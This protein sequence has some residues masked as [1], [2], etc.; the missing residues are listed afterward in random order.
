MLVIDDYKSNGFVTTNNDEQVDAIDVGPTAIATNSEPISA[1][2]KRSNQGVSAPRMPETPQLCSCPSGFY[3]MLVIN[4]KHPIRCVRC[5]PGFVTSFNG[6][7]CVRCFITTSSNTHLNNNNTCA[8]IE[9]SCRAAKNSYL[10]E[11]VDPSDGSLQLECHQCSSTTMADQ[12]THSC[13][14]CPA[15]RLWSSIGPQ[16]N[17]GPNH[18][19][20]RIA[21]NST[22]SMSS[23]IKPQ[24]SWIRPTHDCSCHSQTVV[25]TT[26]TADAQQEQD[27]QITVTSGGLCMQRRDYIATVVQLLAIRP[28]RQSANNNNNQGINDESIKQSVAQLIENSQDLFLIDGS[29]FTVNNREYSNDDESL[30]NRHRFQASIQAEDPDSS[31]TQSSTLNGWQSTRAL[32]KFKYLRS[33]FMSNHLVTAVDQCKNRHNLT[34]CQL[35]SNICAYNLYSYNERDQ[36]RA[37]TSLAETPTRSSYK[38]FNGIVYNTDAIVG[39]NNVCSHLRDYIRKGTNVNLPKSELFSIYIDNDAVD[40]LYKLNIPNSYSMNQ[41]IQIVAFRYAE[42]GQM[43]DIVPF[44][45]NHLQ[46]SL[47]QPWSSLTVSHN[48][49]VQFGD[50]NNEQKTGFEFGLNLMKSC[51]PNLNDILVNSKTM[52]YELYLMIN[53]SGAPLLIR[54]IPVLIRNTLVNGHPVNR[55]DDLSKWVLARRFF[56]TPDVLEPI[57]VSDHGGATQAEPVKPVIRYVKS[58]ELSIRLRKKDGLGL[59]YPPLVTIDYG[60]ASSDDANDE[61]TWTTQLSVI[62]IMSTWNIDRY[63]E[64]SMGVLGVLA[65][66]WSLFQ[67]FKLSKRC[68]KTSIDLHIIV[69]YALITGNAIGTLLLAVN[70]TLAMYNFFTFKLQR[71]VHVLLPTAE[72]E[73]PIKSNLTFA[74]VLKLLGLFNQMYWCLQSDIFF[75][76]WERPRSKDFPANVNSGLAASQITPDRD[77]ISSRSSNTNNNGNSNNIIKPIPTASIWRPYSIVNR[78]IQFQTDRRL[79]ISFHIMVIVFLFDY[80]NLVN[81]ASADNVLSLNS[82]S[83]IFNRTFRLAVLGAVYILASLV[84]MVYLVFVHEQLIRDKLHEFVDL[85]SISM[86]AMLYPRYGFYLHGRSANGMAECGIRELNEFLDREE[87]ELCSKRGLVPNTDHQTF[88]M[89]L[90]GIINQHYKRLVSLS[91]FDQPSDPHLNQTIS[92][93]SGQYD[94]L[95]NLLTPLI[96]SS[97]NSKRAARIERIALQNVLVNKFLMAFIQHGYKDIDYDIREKRT[98]ERLL[99]TEFEENRNSAHLYY[100][101]EADLILVEMLIFLVADIWFSNVFAAAM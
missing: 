56:L 5:P 30:F 34:A 89:V 96:A 86:F 6:F 12:S 23:A 78:W 55:R 79:S 42:D 8:T 87:K 77:I 11:R 73:H 10:T 82:Q 36:F 69:Q 74:L 39:N 64:V 28:D 68:G 66:F 1:K 90:P 24:Y 26:S 94:K 58:F 18:L 60:L 71:T 48:N 99:D 14:P 22:S 37:A 100:G 45:L 51:T 7:E 57:D 53:V 59:I 81:L 16:T 46:E 32:S 67:C 35:W 72:Q 88:Q 9:A 25:R 38:R 29:M 15:A 52:F 63:A 84:Q 33:E 17:V 98:I 44:M 49:N 91:R 95:N 43:V 13:R 27:A 3:K 2:L 40:E 75:I 41:H 50:F 70:F 97:L 92:T 61:Q 21:S 65:S 31:Y 4:S 76:D 85:C 93:V 80:L 83:T 101:I 20:L 47:C 19:R 62:Y 54:P